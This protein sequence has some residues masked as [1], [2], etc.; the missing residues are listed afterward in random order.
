MKE[1]LGWFEQYLTAHPE[2]EFVHRRHPSEWNSPALEELA[3]KCPNFHVI[4]AD[5][6]KQG[7]WQRTPSPSG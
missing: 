1:T 4:F 3:R 2:V 6:V 5:S 7:S